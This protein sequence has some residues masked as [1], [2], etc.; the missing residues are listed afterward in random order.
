MISKDEYLQLKT[1]FYDEDGYLVNTMLGKKVKNLGG[2]MLP[3]IMEVI[4][5]E[6]EGNKTIMEYVSLKF[7]I[8]IKDSFFSVQNMKR[9][10]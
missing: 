2:K 8:D 6:E 4:P 1:E 7:D 5:E 10:R 3:S 9:V